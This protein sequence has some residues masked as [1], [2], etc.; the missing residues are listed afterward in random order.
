MRRLLRLALCTAAMTPVCVAAQ[1][2]APSDSAEA[3]DGEITVTA[4]LRSEPLQEVPIAVTAFSAAG[5]TAQQIDDVNDLNAVVPSLSITSITGAGIAQ[6]YLRGAGQDDSQAASEPPITI[7]VDGVPYT[8][9][10]GALLDIIEFDRVE[11]LRGPQG[12]LYGRNSTGGAVKFVARRPDLNDTRFVGDLT[13]GSNSRIDLRGSFSTPLAP[14]FAVKL[15]AISRNEHGFVKDALFTPGNNR[16][17]RYNDT[18]RQ[19]IR[20][21]ALWEPDDATTV[22]SAFDYTNDDAGPQT[23]VPAISSAPAANLVNGKIVQARTV[24]G[25]R[26]AAPTLYEDQT[27]D[28]RG[29][30][31]DVSHDLGSVSLTGVFGYRGFDLHQG[32]DTDGGPN[33]TSISQTGATVSRGFGFD[34]IRDWSNDTL[35]L[36]LRAAGGEDGPFTWVAGLFGMHEKN[37]SLDFFG[38]FSE[39]AAPQS[40]S[41]FD[42]DQKT[43]SR[44]AFGE[45]S[46]ELTPTLTL[47]AGLRYTVDRKEVSRTHAAGL[48]RP[49]VSGAPYVANA[50]KT[51]KEFTPRVILDWEAVDGVKLYASYS[52]GFQAGAY[53]SFPFSLTTANQPFEPTTVDSYEAGIKSSFANDRFVANLTA[54][55]ADYTDLPS[56]IIGA[57]GAIQVLTNDVRLQGL[58]LE[59]RARPLTGLDLYFI[60]G[61]TDDKFLRSVVAAPAV[62][63][64]TENHL[65]FVP[66]S[67]ARI[68][69]NYSYELGKGDRVVLGANLTYS[70]AFYSSTVNTPFAY[71]DAYTLLGSEITYEAPDA[72]WAISLGGRNLTDKLYGERAGTG[73]GGAIVFGEPRTFYARVKVKL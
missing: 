62:P 36:E 4:R 33:V 20:V 32:S 25:P 71:Q 26:R 18:N 28:G 40:A 55:R 45:A 24:Y 54:F 48:N 67:S 53:Q 43:T 56:S 69:G 52:R 22:Y 10:P 1:N 15:D 41:F 49:V 6:I 27:F 57:I 17:K 59:L 7:Y 21:S 50:S 66:K 46:Y 35:T 5:L 19:V 63:G 72:R 30:V 37:E 65:K 64:Q 13:V 58:E 73:G 3:N 11:V 29:L 38:R 2:L 70:G 23:T 44:A 47:S 60:G 61:L 9:A 14:N 39:P 31:V 51:W 68:G 8:K 34:Y 12:T 42:F 16:P